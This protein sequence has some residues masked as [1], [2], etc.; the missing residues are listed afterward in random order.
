M[1]N[2]HFFFFFLL[3]F[4]RIS[5][6]NARPYAGP[7]PRLYTTTVGLSASLRRSNVHSGLLPQNP[8]ERYRCYRLRQWR[9]LRNA[10]TIKWRAKVTM[11]STC[12]HTHA[13]LRLVPTYGKEHKHGRRTIINLSSTYTHTHRVGGEL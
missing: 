2:S 10:V 1:G 12:T 5:R 9:T 11:K 6:A 13:R 4:R 8:Y 7:P 3:T